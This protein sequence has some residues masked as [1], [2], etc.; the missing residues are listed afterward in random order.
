LEEKDMNKILVR[1]IRLAAFALSVVFFAA[2]Q[3]AAQQPVTA[4][5]LTT[6]NQLVVFNTATPNVLSAPLPITGL[7]AGENILAIDFRPANN[8]LYGLGSSSRLYTINTT[9]GGA[10]Q[11]GAAGAFTLNGTDFGFDFNPAVDR[12]R[13]VSNT[14]QNLRLN[15]NDGTLVAT[16]GNL[17]P[18]MPMVTGAG[19]TNNLPGAVNTTLYVI[20]RSN[21]TLYIQNPPN[22]G[23][24]VPVG[25]LGVAATGPNEFDISSIDNTAYAALVVG[26][27]SRLYIIN[28]QTGAATPV[29]TI[30]TGTGTV[31]RG[32]ALSPLGLGTTSTTGSPASRSFDY[33]GDGKADAALFRLT[34]GTFTVRRSSNYAVTTQQFGVQGDIQVPGDYDGDGR[35]D[36]AVFR[37]GQTNGTFFILNSSN[38]S[39][40]AIQYGLATD[41]PVVRDYDGDGK[42]DLAV[43][44]RTP[45]TGGNPGTLTWYIAQSGS[46]GATRAVQFGFDTDTPAPGDYDGDGRFDIAVY[47]G[48]PGQ[49]AT[50]FV[51]QSSL[52]F[53]AVQFGLGGDLVV[54][55]DYDGDRK[56]DFA[57]LRQ[58]TQFVWYVLRSSNNSILSV[59]WGAKPQ[60]SAQADYDGDGTTDFAT[61]DPNTASFYILRVAGG[62]LQIRLGQNGDYPVANNYSY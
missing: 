26:G 38:N 5:G 61:Y 1:L 49:P 28:L 51:Q 32:L 62:V 41:Q 57:V 12:I 15:P 36:Y 34:N 53:R 54:P 21:N 33:D 3:A 42:A 14:G 37:Q 29:G 52:G 8:V 13:V 16:D 19:Y 18:G 20:D 40:S 9:T 39:F 25:P 17:N 43:V 56:T 22:N 24:L 31:L 30:G 6:N 60:L 11:V 46:G 47:R 23:T 58:G 10:T 55:G 35:T 48:N 59:Q 4:Y 2:S 50:F 27:V 45:G 7:Q 44:R